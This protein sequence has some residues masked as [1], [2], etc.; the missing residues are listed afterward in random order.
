VDASGVHPH[1]SP[2]QSPPSLFRP[3]A[4]AMGTLTTLRIPLRPPSDV[5]DLRLSTAAYPVVGLLVGS[6]PALMLALPLP[7]LPRAALALAVWIAVTGALHVD[8]WGDCCDAAFAPP[9]AT[10]EET[11][12]RRLVILKDP[13]M[14]VFGVTGIGLLLLGKWTALVHA[15][16]V[17]PLAA[18]VLARWAMVYTLGAFPPAR[19]DGMAATLG[20]GVPFWAAT[21]FAIP[22]LVALTWTTD[23]PWMLARA[24]L[25]GTLA[26]VMA[27][28]WLARRFGGITGDVCG[29]VGE[30]TELV[31]LWAFLP[32]G[33]R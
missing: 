21:V 13:R 14:G 28:A 25:A 27:A 22:V 12:Q 19:P 24:V 15:P 32:W 5:D 8:G 9:R 33:A 2:M 20:R 4:V 3:L 10:E 16:A 1:S 23:Q 7:D 30:M 29:A 31:S 11:R 6:L 17:A 26:A 18:A